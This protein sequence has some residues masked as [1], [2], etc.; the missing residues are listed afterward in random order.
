MGEEQ[1]VSST[2][3]VHL[4]AT[5][6]GGQCSGAYLRVGN[7]TSTSDSAAAV[8]LLEGVVGVSGGSSGRPVALRNLVGLA[9]GNNVA[10]AGTRS[11]SSLTNMT[12]AA[13]V[14]RESDACNPEPSDGPS[15]EEP[16][17][18]ESAA[19]SVLSIDRASTYTETEDAVALAAAAD[20]EPPPSEPLEPVDS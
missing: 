2:K 10:C 14:L 19:K 20:H 17:R 4:V 11:D 7:P 16:A 9:V 5:R 8:S 15:T 13:E 12:G 3:A 1:Q 6:G 18:P